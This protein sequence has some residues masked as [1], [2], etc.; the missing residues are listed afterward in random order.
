MKTRPGTLAPQHR[1]VTD[2]NQRQ[3]EPPASRDER[4]ELERFTW[5]DT[6]PRGR[7]SRGGE[8]PPRFVQ[9]QGPSA[10]AASLSELADQVAVHGRRI[11]PDAWGKVK[12]GHAPP[13]VAPAAPGGAWH[14]A[15][16]GALAEGRR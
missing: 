10:H 6:V 9:P 1:D 15:W 13:T 8:D 2:L 12:R 14:E 5:I 3:P 16:S 4:Q 7:S 11:D